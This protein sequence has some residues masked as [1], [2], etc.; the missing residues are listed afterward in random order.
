MDG[1]PAKGAAEVDGD[2]GR[3]MGPAMQ[4][5]AARAAVPWMWAW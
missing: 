3:G 4:T 1:D 2:A 5:V